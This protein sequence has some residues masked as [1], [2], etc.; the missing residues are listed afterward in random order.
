MNGLLHF[1][2]IYKAKLTIIDVF[3]PKLDQLV[4]HPFFTHDPTKIPRSLPSCCT[5]V[6]PDWQEDQNGYLVPVLAEGDE[7]KYGSSS[8]KKTAS[9][10]R[11]TLEEITNQDHQR[12][13]HHHRREERVSSRKATGQFEIFSEESPREETSRPEHRDRVEEDRVQTQAFNLDEVGDRLASCKIDDGDQ[14]TK[15]SPSTDVDTDT[16]E[17][18]YSRLKD[19]G[20]QVEANGGE[21]ISFKP[22]R[23]LERGAADKWVTRYVDY[24][25]KYGLGFLFNDGR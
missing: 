10:P 7:K 14:D 15:A 3:R 19:L 21:P 16:L 20:E 23:P 1:V 18:M 6:A 13:K 22:A 24:T 8:K 12:E 25:S 9:K 2:I 5:H 4:S 17:I 11:S